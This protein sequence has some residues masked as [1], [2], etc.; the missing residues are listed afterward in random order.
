MQKTKIQSLM[1]I[2][3]CVLFLTN[4]EK[5]KPTQEV[6]EL[7]KLPVELLQSTL[8]TYADTASG[9][10]GIMYRVD[11]EGYEPW[12]GVSGFFDLTKTTEIDADNKF[13]VGSITKMFTATIILQ[14]IEEGSI[15]LNDVIINYLP[16]D[17]K[18]VL[19]S[20]QYG[21]QITIYHALSHR[22]GIYN[23]SRSWNLILQVFQN[24]SGQWTNL[25]IIRIVKDE[26]QPDFIPGTSFRYS[27]TNYLLLG[28]TIRY[29]CQKSLSEVFNERI[30][31]K[32]EMENSFLSEDILG[33]NQSGIAHGYD[34]EF[35][36][37][38]D[39]QDFFPITPAAGGMTSTTEELNLFLYKLVNGQLYNNT[40]TF[41]EMV[42]TGNNDW[43]GLGIFV[44]Q[45]DQAGLYYGHGGGVFGTIS[46]TYFYIEHNASITCCITLDGIID[47]V[48][49]DIVSDLMINIILSN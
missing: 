10:L 35:G 19:D 18:A 9:V 37:T 7:K 8:D 5:S 44:N 22:S 38:Y 27:N 25:D 26:G 48:S 1:F 24:P 28:E 21:N 42:D 30:F 17:L 43:Y 11:M 36:N 41:S 16:S 12:A 29:I 23:F 14:L 32:I 46:S 33:S 3:I 45:H 40:S 47:F 2:I 13:L 6:N 49:P 39:G 4:C 31:Q 34:I 15:N 20:I